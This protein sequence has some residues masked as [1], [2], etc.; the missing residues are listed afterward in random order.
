MSKTLKTLKDPFKT[1]RWQGGAVTDPR[2][3]FAELFLCAELFYYRCFIKKLL[4]CAGSAKRYKGALPGDVWLYGHMIHSTLTAAYALS[5]V[6]QSPIVV[7]EAN[8]LN[9]KFYCSGYKGTNLWTDLPRCLSKKE[10][11]NPYLAFGAFF[12]HRSLQQWLRDWSRIVTAALSAKPTCLAPDA[13]AL[14]FYLVKLI[15]AAHL[16]DV[17]ET[18]HIEGTLKGSGKGGGAS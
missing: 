18:T 8:L 7:E 17:R 2:Q 15:E 16:I 14:Y 9:K 11:Y 3:V 6:K 10:Y 1:R 5:T 12:K 4:H 13:L